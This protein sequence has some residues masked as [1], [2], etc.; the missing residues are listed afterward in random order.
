MCIGSLSRPI[1]LTHTKTQPRTDFHLLA[2][3]CWS[4]L[5]WLH[6]ILKYCEN[7]N[8]LSQRN[9][10]IKEYRQKMELYMTRAGIRE[11]ETVTVVRFMSDLS[12]EIR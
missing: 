9:M 3:A 4:C 2:L 11:D 10:G 1:I 6:Q 7:T 8:R 5:T 12:L